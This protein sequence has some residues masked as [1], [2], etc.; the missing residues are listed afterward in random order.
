MSHVP[1]P[2][3]TTIPAQEVANLAVSPSDG[4]HSRHQMQVGLTAF[5]VLFLLAGRCP[6]FRIYTGTILTT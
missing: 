1:T 2:P 3:V 4:S 5:V 6:D